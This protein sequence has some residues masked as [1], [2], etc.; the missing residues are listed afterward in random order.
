MIFSFAARVVA[1]YALS[2]MGAAPYGFLPM[3][4]LETRVA[5]QKIGL[6]F[7]GIKF[8]L[9]PWRFLPD[10]DKA[11]V[12]GGAT[13][14]LESPASRKALDVYALIHAAAERHQIT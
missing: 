12:T 2:S 8:P 1:G 5:A 4:A 11:D 7:A 14:V 3:Q 9:N 10:R 13:P 6:A